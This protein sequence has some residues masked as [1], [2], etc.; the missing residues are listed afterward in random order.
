MV[1]WE[2]TASAYFINV[3]W[4]SWLNESYWERPQPKVIDNCDP[5]NILS[6]G[7]ALW[8]ALLKL[9]GSTF[10]YRRSKFHRFTPEIKLTDCLATAALASKALLRGYR[11]KESIAAAL[12]VREG[13]GAG[14]LWWREGREMGCNGAG[15]DEPYY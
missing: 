8:L 5:P 6:P 3:C 7:Y 15:E 10:L 13:M 2:F 14:E 9:P 1:T 12:L 11:W 4:A